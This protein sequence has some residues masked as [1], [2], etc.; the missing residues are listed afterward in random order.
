MK[1][2]FVIIASV[3]LGLGILGVFLPLLPTTPFLLLSA[4]L[5]AKSSDRLYQWLLNHPI[6]GSYIRDFREEKAIALK[7]K[8]VAIATIWISIGYTVF[9]VVNHKW[10]LQ[11]MLGVIATGVTIHIL[12]YKTK[13]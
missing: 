10:Y 9:F 11:V 8:V 3:S 1:I 12:S 6:L 2:F 7:V 5:Y 4:A 13:R